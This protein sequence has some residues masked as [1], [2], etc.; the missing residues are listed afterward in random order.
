MKETKTL[1]I[2]SATT[3]ASGMAALIFQTLWARSFSI[4]FGSTVQAS[5][6]VFA[7]FLVGLA[8][9]AQIGGIYSTRAGSL[10]RAYVGVEI[11]TGVTAVLVSFLLQF[12]GM[13][14]AALIG[15]AARGAVW[16][17]FP[18]ALSII[19]V[20]AIFMGATFPFL[21]KLA[22]SSGLPL[23]AVRK[24]YGH[25]VLGA[26]LGTIL[27][28][29]VLLG[30]AGIHLSILTAA[31]F[32]F[33]SA[34]LCAMLPKIPDDTKGA[35]PARNEDGQELKNIPSDNTL[36]LVSFL[37]G[38]LVL[39][40]EVVWIRLSSFYIGNRIFAFSTLLASVL[41]LLAAGSMLSDR[42]LG[43][44]RHN[45]S[46]FF[47]FAFLL[48]A[49]GLILSSLMIDAWISHHHMYISRNIGMLIVPQRM[50]LSLILLVPAL[51]P[52]GMLFPAALTC[53]RKIISDTGR[54]AGSFYMVNTAGSMLG[55]LGVGF[56]LIATVGSYGTLKIAVIACAIAAALLFAME[57]ARSKS[58]KALAAAIC[59][60]L[61]TLANPLPARLTF[62]K[63]PGQLLYWNE[64][65][66]GIFQI[67]RSA[68]DGNLVVTNNSTSLVYKAGSFATDFVQQM[69]AH[70]AMMYRPGSKKILVLGSGYGITAG[71]FT[72]YPVNK[73]D[74]VEIIPS[75]I[76]TADFY[77]PYNFS[78]DK[79][80][81][82]SVFADDG[83]HF[84]TRTHE[85][86]DIISINVTDPVLPGSS[87]LFHKEF[88]KAAKRHMAK[89]G[90][91]VHHI[92][93]EQIDF[94][95]GELAREFPY[96]Y[97]YDSYANGFNVLASQS[98]LRIDDKGV[99]SLLRSEKVARALNSIGIAEPINMPAYLKNY[100][101]YEDLYPSGPLAYPEISDN[102]P[103]IEFS[104]TSPVELFFL[105]Q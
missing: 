102:Y 29:Y 11:L 58:L 89:D 34:A 60:A 69:Q 96:I 97:L 55:S 81:R 101:R 86:Y 36:L 100:V 99:E 76:R 54:T 95:L 67:V 62:A 88:Y 22:H 3:I 77:N 75:M 20:P 50:L 27:A 79:D 9:G 83:R 93:G 45:V 72:L 90:I 103:F 49:S 53:S 44:F 104:W 31:A 7:S 21:I 25:N 105:N 16:I 94:T 24:I 1:R 80:P 2:L 47:S 70:L 32:N 91:L 46:L 78:Y 37:S 66:N 51:L 56:G 19:I 52:L 61:L 74:A 5:A 28:G 14:L 68:K 57:F 85:T 92:F 71:T 39:G 87:A 10:I 65:A 4:I 13:D 33:L 30:G 17:E 41:L 63:E 15:T 6:V 8:I 64:D 98:P 59:A 43:R 26:A 84:L 73:I 82:V 18:L 38:A 35:C 12:Y 42:Y 40:L 23:S 48:S